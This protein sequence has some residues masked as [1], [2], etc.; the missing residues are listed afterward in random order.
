MYA[1]EVP[2]YACLTKQLKYDIFVYNKN[3]FIS[4]VYEICDL[5]G[6]DIDLLLQSLTQRTVETYREQV[7][8]DLSSMEVSTKNRSKLTSALWR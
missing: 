3:V 1:W 8:T 7:K 6:C 5:L 2:F 4:E